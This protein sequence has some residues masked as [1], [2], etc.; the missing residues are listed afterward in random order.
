MVLK[1][2]VGFSFGGVGFR[3]PRISIKD[4][5]Y[6]N[7]HYRDPQKEPLKFQEPPIYEL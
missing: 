7:P 1:V 6:P 2:Y 4:P 3:F 5:K